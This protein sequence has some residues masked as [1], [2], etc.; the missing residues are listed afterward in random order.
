[1]TRRQVPQRPDSRTARRAQNRGGK[2][3]TRS[4]T[5]IPN[6][7]GLQAVYVGRTPV[8]VEHAAE[9]T[10]ARRRPVARRVAPVS[11]GR[12]SADGLPRRPPFVHLSECSAIEL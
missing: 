7:A 8:L 4:G 12:S 10:P 1:L 9:S 11:A 6:H 3:S 5:A 2:V